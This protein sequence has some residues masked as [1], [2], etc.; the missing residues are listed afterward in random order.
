MSTDTSLGRAG[1]RRWATVT[2]GQVRRTFAVVGTLHFLAPNAFLPLVPRFLPLRREIVYVSGVAELVC[3]GGLAAKVPWAG[4]ASAAVLLAVWPGNLTMALDVTRNPGPGLVG[5]VK[6]AA[7]WAR[8]PLQIP[9]I[10]A[11]LSVDRRDG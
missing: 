3:A 8:M 11:V 6:V 5:A 7:V 10:K 1:W 9:M 4:R 2:P